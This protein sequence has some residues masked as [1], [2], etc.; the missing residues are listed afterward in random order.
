[1]WII[2]ILLIAL[3]GI[4]WRIG[5]KGG[6]K[7]A[8]SVRRWG[9]A[10]IICLSYGIT[11]RLFL[12]PLFCAVFSTGYGIDSKMSRYIANEYIRRAVCGM[13]YCL[14]AIALLCGNWWL[15]GF[16]FLITIIG[17]C[18]AGNQ[19]FEYNDEREE[20]FIGLIIALCKVG[21]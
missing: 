10:I 4:L 11:Y 16:D 9:V 13:L 6:F 2:K 21:G 8:K 7:F 17:V 20:S 1:M 18:L 15:M 14:P 5:G 3:C 19:K 12:I